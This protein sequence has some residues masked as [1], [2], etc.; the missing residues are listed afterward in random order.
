M[1]FAGHAPRPGRTSA[2]AVIEL[3]TLDNSI[4]AT[5]SNLM[6]HTL[7]VVAIMAAVVLAFAVSSVV[8]AHEKRTIAGGK[9]DVKVG[10][11]NEPA[12]I[13]QPNGATIEIK[14]AGT[15][16]AVTG[17]EKALQV[18]IALGGK[19]LTTLPLVPLGDAPG[20]YVAD[21]T[22][23]ATG[24]YVWT[25]I[26]TI[27][28]NTINEEFDSGPGR[29]DDAITAE[30]AAKVTPVNDDDASPSATQAAT[31]AASGPAFVPLSTSTAPIVAPQA[32]SGDVTAIAA[33]VAIVVVLLAGA[34]LLAGRKPKP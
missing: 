30:E 20:I 18:K 22:P 21:F 7:R 33:T 14:K 12:V 19:E 31:S 28:G 29:F 8:S 3:R 4:F 9:Y 25:F 27:E 13:N 17:V 34:L 10:W 16:D 5:R 24:S 23:P 6:K 26:G 2:L 32:P 15:Q 11:K 1:A